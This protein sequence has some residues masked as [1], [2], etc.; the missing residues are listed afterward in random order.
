MRL[1]PDIRATFRKLVKKGL[2]V[3]R[4]AQL[5]DTSRQTVHTWIN[6]SKHVGREHYKDKPRKPK[7]SRIT[8]D[9]EVSILALR[10]T[11][12]WG[13]GRIQQGLYS[14]P[15]YILKSVPGLVQGVWLSRKAIN[16]VLARHGINGFSAGTSDGSSS[17][18]RSLMNSGR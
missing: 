10:N 3:T 6:R 4:I 12:G 2:S 11:F 9:V 1:S 18:P 15:G 5:F 8:V 17:G 16:D 7:E 14:L 13:T